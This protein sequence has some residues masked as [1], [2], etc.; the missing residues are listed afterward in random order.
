M[1]NKFGALFGVGLIALVG[2][3]QEETKTFV[4][5]GVTVP[6]AGDGTSQDFD[7]DGAE[8]NALPGLAGLLQG[9]AQIDVGQQISDL[10]AA[11]TVL[12]GVDVTSKKFDDSDKVTVNGYLAQVDGGG[13][14]AF[15]GQDNI[16][17]QNNNEFD[18]KNPVIAGGKLSTD[19]SDFLF[20]FPF[21]DINL[22][23]PL[24][25]AVISADVS[26]DEIA[27][28]SISGVVD[29]VDFAEVLG[30]FG[31]GLQG[32]FEANAE[33]GITCDAGA[34]R[35]SAS[36]LVAGNLCT[37]SNADGTATG[38]CVPGTLGALA[39]L[40][41][42]GGLI[43]LDDD[44]DGSIEIQFDATTK[45]FVQN[46]AAELFN[47]TNGVIAGNSAL[48]LFFNLDLDN[49]TNK[50]SLPLGIRFDAKAAI[51]KL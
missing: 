19:Q 33:A 1:F 28:G 3:G 46:E 18:F 49:D 30:G 12:I 8:D 15:D 17:V 44:N 45:S 39:L 4:S 35:V 24:K 48:G 9:A 41:P 34:D 36:C 6:E 40:N 51:H 23:L 14:P 50:D 16:V 21:G 2:C 47:M 32:V 10:M 7:N 42:I 26:A 22:E 37:D 43:D 5:N 29:A 11:G 27:N 13:A 20:V 25:R 38:L 31:T